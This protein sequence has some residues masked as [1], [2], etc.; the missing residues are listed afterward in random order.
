[1]LS[2]SVALSKLVTWS[3]SALTVPSVC[4]LHNPEVQLQTI[5]PFGYSTAQMRHSP[6]IS[7][8]YHPYPLPM[9]VTIIH[10]SLLLLKSLPPS[11]CSPS[12]RCLWF[13]CW[14]TASIVAHREQLCSAVGT[15]RSIIYS[16]L[17]S[18]RFRFRWV[19][20]ASSTYR[21]FFL[22]LFCTLLCCTPTLAIV[23]QQLFRA[24]FTAPCSLDGAGVFWCAT[25][26]LDLA[27]YL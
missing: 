5:L 7:I 22:F 24:T 18:V 13:F 1:M 21:G 15:T 11:Q 2:G 4:V 25:Q 9:I 6:C 26:N 14:A 19:P 17:S 12:L 20:S 16:S 27:C 8:R 10:P 3:L 23:M